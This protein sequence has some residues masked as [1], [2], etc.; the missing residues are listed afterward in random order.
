MGAVFLARV[1]S[2]YQIEVPEEVRA[3]LRL[4]EN[5]TMSFEVL[6]GDAVIARKA[7]PSETVPAPRAESFL[8]EWMSPEDEEAYSSL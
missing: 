5:D 4:G 1:T 7:A 6:G 8:T 3:A 2:D